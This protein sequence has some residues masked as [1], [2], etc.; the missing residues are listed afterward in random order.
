MTDASFNDCSINEGPNIRW[1][2]ARSFRQRKACAR[3]Q[4]FMSVSETF[5]SLLQR[6]KVVSDGE[7]PGQDR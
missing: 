2:E 4:K 7:N 6:G 5:A 1:H 3:R